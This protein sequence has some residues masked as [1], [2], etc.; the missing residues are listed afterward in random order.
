M[1]H[2]FVNGNKRAAFACV[3]VFLRANGFRL[4]SKPVAIYKWM[5]VNLEAGTFTISVIKPWL[6][7]NERLF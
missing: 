6:W 5:I 4:Q 3:D 2:P 7:K 1:H